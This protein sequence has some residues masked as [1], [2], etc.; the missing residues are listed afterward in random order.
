MAYDAN[1]TMQARRQGGKRPGSGRKKGAL[2]KGT[3]ARQ[4]AQLYTA[5]AIE[6]LRSVCADSSAG[7]TA[8][9]QAACKLLDLLPSLLLLTK[10]AL[11]EHCSHQHLA[12]AINGCLKREEPHATGAPADTAA[13]SA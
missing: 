6:V 5:E 9:V 7:E 4:A 11:P 12:N 1:Q 8:R 10:G 2:N 3:V 13:R